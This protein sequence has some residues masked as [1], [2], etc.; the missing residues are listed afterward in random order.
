M[1][2]ALFDRFGGPEVLHTREVPDPEIG[3]ND[4]R[5]RV[6]A[7]GV[8]YHDLLA[9]QGR[10]RG[11]KL[12]R[13]PGHEA[14]GE[15]AEVGT[16]VRHVARG[17]RVLVAASL[18]CGVCP[19]CR[20]GRIDLCQA[21]GG[22]PGEEPDGGYAEYQRVPSACVTRLPESIS[23]EEAAA[24]PCAAA[25]ALEAVR[26]VADVRPGDRVLV[27][28]SGGGLG[29]HA[30]QL[31]RLYGAE[32]IAATTSEA[33]AKR[34]AELGAA[35]VICGPIDSLAARVKQITGGGVTAVIDCVGTA[36]L[37]AS[38]RSLVPGGRLALIGAISGDPVPVKPAVL[39]LK[40]LRIGGT[41]RQADLA[42]V[43][44]LVTSGRLRPIVSRSFALEEAAEAHRLLESR[45]SFGR[46]AL[47]I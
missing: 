16:A 31:A 20:R 34:L 32:V 14:A 4:V 19:P 5:V 38:L 18:V 8:C 44:D 21:A 13:I 35:E 23:W 40:N 45:A 1:R 7:C 27:T 41:T 15:V 29:V 36:T 43:V 46:V 47:R 37:E 3:P 25:T 22:A 28:G 10:Y 2:A 33:K 30:I 9:R 42:D 39:V 6:R 26:A 12:P 24:L 11:L 17:E